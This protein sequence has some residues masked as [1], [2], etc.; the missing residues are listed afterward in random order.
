MRTFHGPEHCI[1]SSHCFILQLTANLRRY[2]YCPGVLNHN[3]P[4]SKKTM[5]NPL[6][7]AKL[8][9]CCAQG[10]LPV[11]M[12][13]S[14]AKIHAHRSQQLLTVITVMFW[15]PG[16]NALCSLLNNHLLGAYH[17]SIIAIPPSSTSIY[18]YKM[19]KVIILLYRAMQY[20]TSF[21]PLQLC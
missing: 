12:H 14:L 2:T 21:S 16:D 7:W 8:M 3:M 10:F 17:N 5:C 15:R 1:L 19:Q 11:C 4:P 6:L 18:N 9:P 20:G 13:S